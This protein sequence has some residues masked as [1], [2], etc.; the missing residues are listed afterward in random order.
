MQCR[1]FSPGID[2]STVYTLGPK[3]HFLGYVSRSMITRLILATI[4]WSQPATVAVVISAMAETTDMFHIYRKSYYV[5]QCSNFCTLKHNGTLTKIKTFVYSLPMK[6][7]HVNEFACLFSIAYSNIKD[8]IT[9]T[10]HW[11][12]FRFS[13]WWV[14]I[15]LYSGM[16]HNVVW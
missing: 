15:W 14:Q 8:N 5:W 3:P 1:P 13:W 7:R 10:I 9:Q 16:L 6:T 11:Q 2:N 12:D 4:P